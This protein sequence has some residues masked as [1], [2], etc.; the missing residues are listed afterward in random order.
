VISRPA[1]LALVATAA[2]VA[3][4][5]GS[6]SGAGAGPV[7]TP[8]P[9]HT[10]TKSPTPSSP[11]VTVTA[12]PSTSKTVTAT[13][14][15]TPTP[16]STPK[17][18]P[19]G[20]SELAASLGASQG[21]AGSFYTAVVLTNKSHSACTMVGYPGVSYISSSG[22]AVG[23]PASRVKGHEATVTVKPGGAASALLH[24]PNPLVFQPADCHKKK[25]AGIRIYPPGQTLSLTVDKP[26]TVCTTTT[27]RSGVTPMQ[28]GTNPTL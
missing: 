4:C 19:C 1:V 13:P 20:T 25:A 11:P 10:R 21:A 9:S 15:P 17:V 16:T 6:S 18:E 7:P 8:T 12:S 27:G 3:G 22:A 2:V 24:Q 28:P 26:T 23:Q 14:T 5:G